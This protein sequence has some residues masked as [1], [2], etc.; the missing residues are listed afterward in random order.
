M[1]AQQLRQRELF[2][3]D[4]LFIKG[5]PA[6]AHASDFDDSSWRRLDLPHDWSVEGHWAEENPSGFQGGYCELGNAWYRKHFRLPEE[7]RGKRVLLEIDGAY[8][9]SDVWINGQKVGHNDY[10]YIGY[11]CDL[12]PWIKL[13]GKNVIAVRVDNQVQSQR[14]YTGSGIYRHVWLSAV[15]AL[16]VAHW[17]TYITTPEVSDDQATVRAQII[18]RNDSDDAISC[19]V[20][21]QLVA[22]SR[23]TVGTVESSVNVSARG[24]QIVTQIIRVAKP[25][26][27]DIE[28]P[29]LYRAINTVRA[30]ERVTD[31]YETP[32][33][34]RTMDWSVKNG[35]MLNGRRVVIKGMN[36]HADWGA[37]GTA[38]LDRAMERRL[39]V[40]KEMGCN[41]VRLSHHPHAPEML[42][43]CDRMGLLVFAES[44]DKWYGF[45]PDGTGWKDDLRA[46]IQRDRNHPSIFIWSVG[47]EVVPHQIMREGTLLYRAMQDFVHEFEPTRRVTI[48]LH[49]QR[50]A[51]GSWDG[52]LP[53]IA[54]SMDVITMNYMTRHYPS[55][56]VKYPNQVFL[57]G[58]V[59]PHQIYDLDIPRKPTDHAAQTWFAV[60]DYFTNEYVDYVAGQFV[61]AGVDYFGEA[62]RWLWPC[63]GN[64]KNLVTTCGF[65]KSFSYYHQSLYT[66]EPVVWLAVNPPDFEAN[67][68]KYCGRNWNALQSHWNWQVGNP[69][70]LRVYSFTNAPVVELLLNGK[71]L[72]EKRLVDYGERIITW[73]VPNEPGTLKAIAK[74]DGAIIATHEL[75]T[76]GN[77]VRLQLIPDRNPLIASGQDLAHVEVRAVDANGCLAPQAQTMAIFTIG[78]PGTIVGVDNG[79]YNSL[80]SYKANHRELRDGRCLVIVQSV[81]EPGTIRLSARGGGL[82]TTAIEIEVQSTSGA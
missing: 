8:N 74:R 39:Q 45:Q 77:A 17:G 15:D 22:P 36:L 82:G 27:W 20:A 58:E 2:D 72:G 38:S 28:S 43:L 64:N 9:H 7:W 79:D 21:T 1:T 30:G 73:D 63:K 4:W 69:P 60:Q 71:S 3:F 47:N 14:W 53:D 41:A 55:D 35:F 32:F 67:L 37:L 51:D 57:S 50:S 31:V 11:E 5:D 13:G 46:F 62:K 44:V 80:E 68:R 6:S 18:L 48:A 40:I 76:A 75:K 29:R 54:Q 25:Q 24:E 66:T 61:W 70:T 59:Q 23:D 33:G 26:R 42:D 78:G 34:I 81:R 49:P 16:R 65:R 12:T 52:E 10:G 19:I 56:H